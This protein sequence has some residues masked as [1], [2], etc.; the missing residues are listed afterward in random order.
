MDDLPEL[1]FEKV[2]S[3]LSLEDLLKA[4]AVSRRWRDTIDSFRVKSLCY[5][6]HPIG[7][8]SEKNRWVNGAFVQNF[9]FS[10]RFSFGKNEWNSRAFVRSYLLSTQL[11]MF[12]QAY[13][14]TILS[15]LLHL[16]LCELN[17]IDGATLQSFGR[18]EKL[19]LIRTECDGRPFNLNLPMLNSIRF[20]GGHG[21]KM[22]LDAPRLVEVK[23]WQGSLRLDL[24]HGESVEKLTIDDLNRV[25]VKK[26]KNLKQLYTGA[27]S[28]IDST[29]LSSLEQLKEAHLNN[30][31][32]VSNLFDQKRRYNC[33]GLKIYLHGLLL[34]GPDDPATSS[35]EALLR[36]SAENPSRTA[37]EIP[38]FGHLAYSTIESVVANLEISV[39]KRF[40]DLCSIVVNQRVQD[41]QRFLDV[42]KN[43]ESIVQLR[44]ESDQPQDLFDRLPEHCEVQVLN[45]GDALADLQFLLRLKH[46]IHLRLNQSIDAEFIR[47]VY[48]ELPFLS[49][50]GFGCNNKSVRIDSGHSKGFKA[51]MF[52]KWT[53]SQGLNAT[54][55]W[56]I[57]NAAL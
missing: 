48:E 30:Q 40:T 53:R 46:L 32:E 39:F 51:V 47:N 38:P 22:F 34:N 36:C 18:L 4:R 31:N 44:F 17:L 9:I 54:I 20:E 24:V 10:A 6:P 21:I 42:L 7:F 19:D 8:I 41:V 43:L 14:E 27:S 2:L 57:K 11:P 23:I 56:I 12:I 55:Q 1:P 13:G 5:S 25:E 33:A 15:N 52:G 29:L 50:F 37:D 16:R 3:Y 49:E 45:I 28:E 26:L 35:F